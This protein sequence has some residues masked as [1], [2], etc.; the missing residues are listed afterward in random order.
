MIEIDKFVSRHIGP[1]NEDIGEMLKLINCSSLDELIEKTVPNHIIF[2]D[3]LKFRPGMS[4]EFNKINTQLLSLKNNFKKT[5]IG[6][7]YYNT[8]TPSVILRNILEN[9]GWYT[10]YT[11][12][13]P[14]VSQGRLEMLMN[15]QQIL[16]IPFYFNII[17]TA[18]TEV[19]ITKYGM[20]QRSELFKSKVKFGHE[21]TEKFGHVDQSYTKFLNKRT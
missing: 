19:Q 17:N 2:K 20:N 4:E 15:F 8:I 1:R 14:E 7:G 5:Y 10:A 12:Y 21:Y 6:M 11:P 9:P 16:G 18:F 13:Q 3:K